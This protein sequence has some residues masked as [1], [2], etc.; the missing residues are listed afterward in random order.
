VRNGGKVGVHPHIIYLTRLCY[1][2]ELF[3]YAITNSMNAH[4]D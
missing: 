3:L 1:I 2:Q 4:Y